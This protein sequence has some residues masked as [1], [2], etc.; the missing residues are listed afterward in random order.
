MTLAQLRLRLKQR[1]G[2]ADAG[3]EFDTPMLYALNSAQRELNLSINFQELTTHDKTSLS[4]IA[5]TQD[6]DL[7][8]DFLK[9]IMIWNNDAYEQELQRIT[10]R[11][12]KNYMGD[13]DTETGTNPQHYDILDTSSNVKRITFFPYRA[14]VAT[15]AI[16]AF[17]D[18]SG[19]VAGAVKVTDASH[20]LITGNSITI[21][22]TTNYN[23]TYTITS[24]DSDTFY[25]TATWVATETGTWTRNHYVPFVYIQKVDDLVNPTDSNAITTYYPDLLLEGSSYYMYRDTIY[26]DDP[27]KIAFRRGEYDR[28]IAIVKKAQTQTDLIHKIAP[29]RI[30][31]S[32]RRRFT[33]QTTGYPS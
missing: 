21:A 10:P 31:P 25:I 32:T 27:G 18:Y 6:Y 7:P 29:K 30:L 17:A 16:T 5:N 14:S 20:G 3:D 22:G 1:I 12:Y 28:Q 4:L 15:G 13:V 33:V 19:T 23:G 9:M 24:I 2:R 26:R 11:A 8:S